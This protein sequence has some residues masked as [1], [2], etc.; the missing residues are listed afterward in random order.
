MKKTID[1]NPSFQLDYEKP[2]KRFFFYTFENI[3]ECLKA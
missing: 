3:A 2:A 1:L